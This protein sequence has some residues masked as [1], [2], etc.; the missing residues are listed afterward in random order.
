MKGFGSNQK[1]VLLLLYGGVG[2][3]LSGSPR[4]YF[5]VIKSV[6]DEW[7]KINQLALKRAIK[8]LYKSR[9]IEERINENGSTTMVLTE[10]GKTKALQFN[11]ETMAIN[12]PE[13]WDKKWRMILFDIP[14]GKDKER[15]AFRAMLK[16]LGFM[17]YQKSAFILP[18]ECKNEVEYVSEFFRLR[19]FVRLV[20]IH[21]LDDE[22]VF[23]EKFGLV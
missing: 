15:E 22:L 8:V 21:W 10:N 17:Q 23:K 19:P 20:E 6:S 13:L 11:I 5:G 7:S 1:K 2:L 12:K 9:L 3:A 14:K 18:Y 4:A 16:R